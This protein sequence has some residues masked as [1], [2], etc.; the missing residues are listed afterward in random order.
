MHLLFSVF[1]HRGAFSQ[2]SLSDLAPSADPDSDNETHFNQDL[3]SN[4]TKW[5]LQANIWHKNKQVF[6]LQCLY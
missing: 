6:I 3:F 2:N 1:I 5:C 4:Q